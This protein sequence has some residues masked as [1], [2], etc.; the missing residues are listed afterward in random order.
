M[1]T[2]LSTCQAPY[3]F[4]SKNRCCICRRKMSTCPCTPQDAMN[5]FVLCHIA[6]KCDKDGHP[7]VAQMLTMGMP[8]P[9][10]PCRNCS[11]VI[12]MVPMDEPANLFG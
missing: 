4:G 3:L 12:T 7:T 5:H 1:T 10:E 11:E 2:N 8:A 9:T 6:D